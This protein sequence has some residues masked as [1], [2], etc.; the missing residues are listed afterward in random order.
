MAVLHGAVVDGFG[1]E[2]KKGLIVAER[3]RCG[4]LFGLGTWSFGN[5]PFLQHALIRGHA[6]F[7]GQL[8]RAFC[9]GRLS[10]PVKEENEADDQGGDGNTI[11]MKVN[12]FKSRIEV[13]V[14]AHRLQSIQDP[15]W[16]KGVRQPG[17]EAADGQTGQQEKGTQKDSA[18]TL[19]K[20]RSQWNATDN[21]FDDN[22]D[23]I[24]EKEETRNKHQ[25]DRN[26]QTKANIKDGQARSQGC[27]TGETGKLGS[28]PSLA[29]EDTGRQEKE[30][31][32][33]G[34]K[35]SLSANLSCHKKNG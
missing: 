15:G 28:D 23:E 21:G 35:W 4:A 20:F 13:G 17:E 32:D 3:L 8:D 24:T 34:G 2:G 1:L 16:E 7:A 29:G 9:F 10:Y 25:V 11:P 27:Q 18:E 22:Y 33:H 26:R 14:D 19:G 31:D 6:L 30:H 5:L 12:R